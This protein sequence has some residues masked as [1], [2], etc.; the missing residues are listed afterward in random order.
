MNVDSTLLFLFLTYMV[1][2]GGAGV[3]TY[4]L[5]EKAR[6]LAALTAEGKRYASIAIAAILAMA[7]FV[8]AVGLQ[9]HPRPETA[10]AW[11]EALFAVAFM[12]TGLSQILHGRLKL[13]D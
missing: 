9:Y 10:Q 6:F 8:F 11:L 3:L 4:F 7:F 5:M 12:A 1:E 13:R 2:G